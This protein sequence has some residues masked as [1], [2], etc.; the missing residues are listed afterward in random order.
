MLAATSVSTVASASYTPL[1]DTLNIIIQT[2]NCSFLFFLPLVWV[3][4]S[5]ENHYHYF[6]LNINRILTEALTFASPPGN[7][8]W[9]KTKKKVYDIIDPR[10]IY[11]YT[12]IRS[13]NVCVAG[14]NALLANA[15]GVR[16]TA[17]L[18]FSSVSTHLMKAVAK[19]ALLSTRIFFK[20]SGQ[21][22]AHYRH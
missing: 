2:L 19:I 14:S 12:S 21:G 1:T 11:I 16:A 15:E 17:I 13:S 9:A 4:S 5:I 8:P 7:F 22:E 10:C 18:T 6:S 20:L 3:F